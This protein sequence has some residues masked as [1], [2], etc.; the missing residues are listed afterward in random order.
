MTAHKLLYMARPNKNGTYTFKPREQLDNPLLKVIIVDELSMI[1]GEMWNLLLSHRVHVIA[2]GDPGQ[3]PVISGTK[4]DL[5]DHP[6]AFLSEIVRQAAENEIIQF[7]MH[8]RNSRPIATYNCKNQNVKILNKWQFTDDV[9][10]WADMI[11]CSTNDKRKEI[12]QHYRELLGYGEEPQ[13]GDKIVSLRN[14]WDFTSEGNDEVPLTN[15]TIGTIIKMQKQNLYTLPSIYQG[16]IP[17]LKIDMQA[18]DGHIF[19]D[20]ILDYTELTT[21]EPLLTGEQQYQMRKKKKSP[22]PPFCFNY[23]YCLSAHRSQGSEWRRVVFV[24]EP[25][26]YQYELRKKLLYTAATRGSERLVV[27]KK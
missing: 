2:M 20:I 23:A 21:G 22:D 16:P 14:Q 15:G 4:L 27:I 7:S 9:Y 3:I 6:H 13:I 8:L 26:P 18:E 19:K 24:E 10:K 1:N 17:V 12:N 25:W 11:I 5:L